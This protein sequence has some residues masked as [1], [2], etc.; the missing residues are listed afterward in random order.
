MDYLLKLGFTNEDIDYIS[1]NNTNL[2]SKL[3][4]E[5]KKIIIANINSLINLG[6]KNYKEIFN[7]YADLFLVEHGYFEEMINKYDEEDLVIKLER[8]INIFPY[9]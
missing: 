5:Q 9:L 2:I 1:K 6:V 8:N 3:L 4:V 7:E